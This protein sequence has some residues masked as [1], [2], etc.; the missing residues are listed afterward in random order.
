MNV[1]EVEPE[2]PFEFFTCYKVAVFSKME[3]N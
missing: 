2:L 1:A 3:D